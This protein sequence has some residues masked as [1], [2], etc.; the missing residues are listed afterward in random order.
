MANAKSRGPKKTRRWVLI[1]DRAA[2]RAI[3]VGGILVIAAV[4]GMMVF[5]VYEVLPLFQG[6][7]VLSRADYS[8]S[9]DQESILGLSVDDYGTHS[10]GNGPRWRRH[11]MA[12]EDRCAI[13]GSRVRL[14]GGGR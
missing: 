13:A 6:G 9:F 12:R 7:S 10:R 1:V 2:D 11:R 5:L 14:S 4:L 3:T 8:L